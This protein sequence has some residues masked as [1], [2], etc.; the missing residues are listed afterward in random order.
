MIDL[1]VHSNKSDGSLTPAELV[2][3]ALKAGV[4]AFALTDHDTTDGIDEAA[5]AA[6][7]KPL[8]VI[9]GIEFSTEYKGKDIHILG[10]YI[11]HH[12]PA[13][14][15][16]IHSFVEAR[17]L[18]N[19][20]MCARLQEA[21]IAISYEKLQAEFPGSVITRAH[22]ARFLF[23][24]GYVHSMQEA[25][26]HY[27]GDDCPYYVPREKITPAQAVTLILAAGGVPILAHPTLYHMEDAQLETLVALLARAG[28]VGIEAIYA[29]YTAAE[30]RQMRALAAKYH[31]L[32]S[33]GSDFHGAAKPGLALGTGYGTLYVPEELLVNIKNYKKERIKENH[34]KKKKIFFTDLD[35]TLLNDA[36]EITPK[37]KE[38]LDYI[39]KNGHCITLISG[40]PIPSVLAAKS[41]LGLHYPGMYL[42]GYNGGCIYDCDNARFLMEKRVTLEDAAR[43][44]LTAKE[45]GVYCQT[46]TDTHIVT[47]THGKEL[48]FYRQTVH[49]PVHVTPDI[50]SMLE[51]PPLKLFA[52]SLDDKKK[53]EDFR[54][55][56]LAWAKDRL[57]MVYSSDC[58]LE[59]FPADSGKGS[60]LSY[61]C[62]HLGVDKKDTLAAG[63]ADNDL[64][65]LLAAGTGVAMQN[66]SDTVK[67]AASIV[68]RHDNNN[69]G[70]ADIL[71]GFFG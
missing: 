5:A 36:K 47:N 38:A 32:L 61:L 56:L 19:E 42:I 20:K 71:L 25:F 9:P 11:D 29:S 57:Q 39:V 21:G 16:R 48:D 55:A 33:G 64:S 28:L 51:K 27:V 23:Q 22:Y 50:L 18:R 67:K 14:A 6:A 10:L 37:T 35:G 7:G 24:H 1:H 44:L 54:S 62:K 69:D 49:M 34:P 65:M 13:F 40:R 3:Y 12:A 66:G 45:C 8:E 59:I 41:S 17:T 30:E 31:L 58:Y 52:I 4:S 70:L 43:V 26:L 53:L 2:A 15:S 68:T 60:A 63:D 46:Y